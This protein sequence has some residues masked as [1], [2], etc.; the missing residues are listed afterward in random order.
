MRLTL[1]TIVLSLCALACSP[2]DDAAPVSSTVSQ[3]STTSAGA[4]PTST[5]PPVE[6]AAGTVRVGVLELPVTL[7]PIADGGTLPASTVIQQAVLP[8]AFVY[9]PGTWR[10]VPNLVVRIPSVEEGDVTLDRNRQTVTWLI[11]PEATWSDGTPVSGADFAFTLEAQLGLTA[12]GGESALASILGFE[13]LD[14]DEK[15]VTV[16]MRGPTTGYESMFA[17]VLPAHATD[18]TT[19]CA[20]N[21]VGWPSAGPFVAHEVTAES[22]TIRRNDAYWRGA[23]AVGV[24][25]FLLYE[26]A[27]ALG[28]AFAEG[29]VDL[30]VTQ[31]AELASEIET[32]GGVKLAQRGGRAEHL[33]FNFARSGPTEESLIRSVLFRRAVARAIDRSALVEES[34]GMPI[35]GVVRSVDPSDPWAPLDHDLAEAVQLMAAACEEDLR[36]CVGEPPSLRLIASDYAI[37]PQLVELIVADLTAIGVDVDFEVMSSQDFFAALEETGWDMAVLGIGE[38]AG[39]SAAASLMSQTIAPDSIGNV[40]S[41]GGSGSL[42]A[43]ERTAFQVGIFV[44]QMEVSPSITR[45]VRLLGDVHRLLANDVVF[46]PLVAEPHFTLVAAER[47]TGVEANASPSGVTWNIAEWTYTDE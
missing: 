18:E 34:G 7:N 20:D 9:D 3:T 45:A 37:R 25:Q 46:V 19:V 33:A 11:D 5:V 26:S 1:M 43:T 4:G 44:R 29:D 8:G 36:D 40:Y 22:V 30:V 14:V 32:V 31:D 41:Y 6:T 38:K 21:G 24:V 17:A 2:A 28:T 39:V 23:P 16:E 27:D 10:A 13:I 15:S 35:Y 47:L 12:C 42:V